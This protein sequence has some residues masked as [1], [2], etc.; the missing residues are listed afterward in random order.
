M[1]HSSYP[2]GKTP[3]AGGHADL[4]NLKSLV[5]PGHNT[6]LPAPGSHITT[7]V[8]SPQSASNGRDIG[9]GREQVQLIRTP[10][11]TEVGAS[12]AGRCSN[13]ANRS[14]DMAAGK[15]L[16]PSIETNNGRYQ[17]GQP[18]SMIQGPTSRHQKQRR[19]SWGGSA[20]P[21]RKTP[22]SLGS[23]NTMSKPPYQA[24]STSNRSRE[25]AAAHE[26]NVKS[27]TGKAIAQ[28]EGSRDYLVTNP[29]TKA[30][31]TNKNESFTLPSVSLL[32]EKIQ[33]ADK[34]LWS[35]L[36][37]ANERIRE[38]DEKVEDQKN[39][40]AELKQQLKEAKNMAEKDKFKIPLLREGVAF[41]GEEVGT[42]EANW[43]NSVKEAKEARLQAMSAASQSVSFMQELRI[44]Q[45]KIL[46][47][48]KTIRNQERQ[49]QGLQRRLRAFE[50]FPEQLLQKNDELRWINDTQID[51]DIKLTQDIDSL[52][53]RS[54]DL[55]AELTEKEKLIDQL[56]SEAQQQQHEHANDIRRL[57]KDNTLLSNEIQM[58]QNQDAKGSTDLDGE[59]R[60]SNLG[61]E[62]RRTNDNTG[63]SV[64]CHG[65]LR[66]SPL[67]STPRRAEQAGVID[68]NQVEEVGERLRQPASQSRSV[69]SPD[70]GWGERS[71][72]RNLSVESSSELSGER[73]QKRQAEVLIA[74]DQ[75]G[76]SRARSSVSSTA[77][78]GTRRASAR[79]QEAVNVDVD[80]ARAG[81]YPDNV[82][83]EVQTMLT[84]QIRKWDAIRPRWTKTQAGTYCLH[85]RGVNRSTS[86]YE[87]DGKP[88]H[89][90]G[91][92]NCKS[93]GRACV[94]MAA[95][96]QLRIMP[97]AYHGY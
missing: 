22:R 49:A 76:A 11:E 66:S 46:E 90:H 88:D 6:A 94:V 75:R 60:Q 21:K 43:V 72:S 79:V 10:Q 41:L 63:G 14:K 25:S 47:Q 96:G 82:P 86:W 95:P 1:E 50:A 74:G 62:R 9:P 30:K 27:N 28:S 19:N 16:I 20:G 84:E 67:L 38:Q 68:D 29:T 92:R 53:R 23:A 77:N 64:F 81:R 40:I 13:L 24:P 35:H 55:E 54:E 91:C 80:E 70:T 4:Q 69:H 7:R 93:A 56:R 65:A 18:T 85:A 97:E 44:T 34:N 89:E 3:P 87:V 59:S 73:R 57:R 39:T 83:I 15:S 71:L 17:E 48:Q 32:E 12:S 45:Q 58:L 2:E 26:V 33:K 52:M 42:A 36:R 5:R 51:L 8:I 37:M 31:A 61:N 78:M